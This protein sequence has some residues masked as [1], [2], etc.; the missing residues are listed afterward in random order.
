LI[1]ESFFF[2]WVM[3]ASGGRPLSA[4]IAHGTI[5]AFVSLF[6]T[7]VMEPDVVQVRWWIHQILVLAAGVLFMLHFTWRGHTR[8]GR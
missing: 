5:N 2:S 8:D 4:I 6:P 1:G 3:K 7:I